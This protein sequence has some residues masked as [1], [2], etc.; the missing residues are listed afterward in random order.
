MQAKKGMYRRMHV[1]EQLTRYLARHGWISKV[2]SC[3]F[4]PRNGHAFILQAEWREHNC[5]LPQ[6][7]Q[8]ERDLCLQAR[9]QPEG[10][11]RS[12]YI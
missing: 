3:S 7:C 1:L 9:M 8:G 4:C 2:T 10:R 12:D 5:W 11:Q 6:G